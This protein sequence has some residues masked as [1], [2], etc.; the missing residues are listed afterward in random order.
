MPHRKSA[1]AGFGNQTGGTVAFTATP[2]TALHGSLTA[3]TVT[4]S[5]GAVFEAVE[6]G[7]G[8][9]FAKSQTY[10]D[11]IVAGAAFANNFTATSFSPVFGASLTPDATTANAL[12]LNLKF[13][14]FANLQGLSLNGS[15]AAGGLN[16]V[17][18]SFSAGS[19]PGAAPLL[20]AVFNLDPAGEAAALNGPLSGS[21]LAQTN[22]VALNTA[23]VSTGLIQDRL[24]PGNGS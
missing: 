14:S 11:V 13:L 16:G 17:F 9:V 12:D 4:A 19:A 2:N 21:T 5:P 1:R 18:N 3:G 15:A 22:F 23:R 6:Q 20:A 8:G 24:A 10:T 7:N